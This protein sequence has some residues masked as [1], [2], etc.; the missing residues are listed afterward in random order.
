M[1]PFYI[2]VLSLLAVLGCLVSFFDFLD[3]V[4]D[5]PPSLSSFLFSFAS[6]LF[7]LTSPNLIFFFEFASTGVEVVMPL[8]VTGA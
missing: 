3:F 1:T 2:A 6:T 4:T 7:C 5:F 8:I